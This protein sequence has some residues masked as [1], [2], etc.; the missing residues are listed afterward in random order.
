MVAAAIAAVLRPKEAAAAARQHSCRPRAVHRLKQVD[1]AEVSDDDE[2]EDEQVNALVEEAAKQLAA[3]KATIEE[4]RDKCAKQDSE[5]DEQHRELAEANA[6]ILELR[7]TREK[8]EAEI[9]HLVSKVAQQEA[10]L[11]KG[12]ESRAKEKT[13][14]GGERERDR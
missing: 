14:G 7:D 3:A 12:K 6:A 13:E 5:S 2:P 1:K 8:H 10:E 11:A 9:A 4:L